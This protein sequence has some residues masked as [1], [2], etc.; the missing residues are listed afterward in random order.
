MTDALKTK[1]AEQDKLAME[2]SQTLADIAFDR[3]PVTA[4]DILFKV[5]DA[6][7]HM[8]NMINTL[9]DHA[10]ELDK[11]QITRLVEAY[12]AMLVARIKVLPYAE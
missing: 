9:H 1:L 2:I 11:T 4:L 10:G 6:E 3:L 8:R 7:V 12:S 5:A